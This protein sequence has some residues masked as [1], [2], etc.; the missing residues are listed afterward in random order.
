VKEKLGNGLTVVVAPQPGIPV[1][2]IDV[3][4]DVGSRV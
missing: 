3:T 4:Y 2:T 1:V